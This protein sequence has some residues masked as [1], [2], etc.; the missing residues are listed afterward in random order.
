MLG[1]LYA[2]LLGT[3]HTCLVLCMHAC[4][5]LY[6]HAWYSVCLGGSYLG[7]DREQVIVMLRELVDLVERRDRAHA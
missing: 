2:C 4:L 7:V 5:V 1:T 3:L 6:M